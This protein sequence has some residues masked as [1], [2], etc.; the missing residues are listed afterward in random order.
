MTPYRKHLLT[1][2]SNALPLLRPLRKVC[3]QLTY[4]EEQGRERDKKEK[5]AGAG[6]GERQVMEGYQRSA[7]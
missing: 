4:V 1:D 5:M 3:L 6:G 7:G 2:E